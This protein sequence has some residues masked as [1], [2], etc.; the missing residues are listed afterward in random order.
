MI[1]EGE[2]GIEKRFD[3]VVTYCR[4]FEGFEVFR[5]SGFSGK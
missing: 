1:V 4:G 5:D 3:V 2:F